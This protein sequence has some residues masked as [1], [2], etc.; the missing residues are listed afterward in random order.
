MAA[1]CY[2]LEFF[3]I[4]ISFPIS[5]CFKLAVKVI[6]FLFVYGDL[7]YYFFF[8]LMLFSDF[9]YFILIYLLN[10]LKFF[11]NT[12]MLSIWQ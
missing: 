10:K 5:F 7:A 8:H 9:K 6:S 11:C 4:I 12:C 3:K 1:S 2:N